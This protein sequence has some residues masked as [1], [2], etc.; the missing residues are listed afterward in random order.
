MRELEAVYEVN[1]GTPTDSSLVPI[2]TG[3]QIVS[4]AAVLVTPVVTLAVEM[5]AAVAS[6]TGI[7][8]EAVEAYTNAA[9]STAAIV[10]FKAVS[11]SLEVAP[12]CSI[13]VIT[14]VIVFMEVDVDVADTSVAV[15]F[16]DAIMDPKDSI[17]RAEVEVMV[18]VRT[19]VAPIAIDRL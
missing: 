2:E 18:P 16:A 1:T 17:G 6:A 10:G 9:T 12:K 13:V 7:M 15:C 11:D 4:F 5:V 8:A 3:N 19:G 14:A